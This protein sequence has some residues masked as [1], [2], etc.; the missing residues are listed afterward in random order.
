M[1]MVA[2]TE[3]VAEGI[4]FIEIGDIWTENAP[5]LLKCLEDYFGKDISGADLPPHSQEVELREAVMNAAPVF[6]QLHDELDALFQNG[7]GIP[8]FAILRM[9]SMT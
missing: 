1:E 9:K 5:K 2:V 6:R 3:N 7:S 8:S 4:A